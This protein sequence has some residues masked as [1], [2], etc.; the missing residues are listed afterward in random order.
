MFENFSLKYSLNK[1]NQSKACV[2]NIHMQV[3]SIIIQNVFYKCKF[4]KGRASI[5]PHLTDLRKLKDDCNSAHF[6]DTEL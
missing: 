1:N 4:R 2:L 3:L 5:L 6:T